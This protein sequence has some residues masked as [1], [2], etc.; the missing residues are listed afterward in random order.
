VFYVRADDDD[1]SLGGQDSRR[2][3]VNTYD[4]DYSDLDVGLTTFLFR[5]R[6]QDEELELKFPAA[7]VP[8]DFCQRLLKAA[9]SDGSRSMISLSFVAAVDDL[10]VDFDEFREHASVPDGPNIVYK[11]PQSP[12]SDMLLELKI[13][14]L[15]DAP[16]GW[17]L[18]DFCRDKKPPPSTGASGGGWGG[19]GGLFDDADGLFGIGGG[20]AEVNEFENDDE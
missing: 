1:D 13:F 8:H 6:A 14:E 12:A 4:G 18:V 16:N 9:M 15:E 2:T 7:R 3:L 20:W 11:V 17:K 10:T 19:G 5:G